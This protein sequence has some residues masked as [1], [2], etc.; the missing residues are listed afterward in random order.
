MQPHE[1]LRAAAEIIR[2]SGW[3]QGTAARDH[4]GDKVEL[5]DGVKGDMSRAGVNGAAVRFSIYGALVK[6]QANAGTTVANPGLMW[7][8][9]RLLAL[10][11]PGAPA[12]G[13]ANYVHPVIGYNDHEGRTR[14][15]VLS[16][17]EHCAGVV[18]LDLTGS[19][20]VVIEP[21]HAVD[22]S[23]IG[24]VTVFESDHEDLY[25]HLKAVI[26]TTDPAEEQG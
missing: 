3:S 6:A 25:D 15:E 20:T 8:T 18:E 23:Q 21:R 5:F 16:F 13:G 14:Q 26:A 19:T 17:L 12:P 11:E 4:N 7:E 22:V 24:D 1:L 2:T 10:S 9:L